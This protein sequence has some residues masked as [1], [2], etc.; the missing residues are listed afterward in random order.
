MYGDT[1]V[2]RFLGSASGL[3]TNAVEG[4]EAMPRV[5][6]AVLLSW[7]AGWSAIGWCA[8]KAAEYPVP[9]MEGKPCIH[10]IHQGRSVRVQRV[11]DPDF[12]LKGYYAKTT[13][14]FPPFC[15]HS[16]RA[17]LNVATVGEVELFEFMET[18]LRYGAGVLA[19]A[20]TPNWFKKWT[21]PGAVNYPFTE[22]SKLP[23]HPAW[24]K[25]LS[26]LG[27]QQI[28]ETSPGSSKRRLVISASGISK[29]VNGIS[30]T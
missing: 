27:A 26:E 12:E 5:L 6:S 15:I 29:R 14:R 25:V 11:Q 30:P 28:Q 1:R 19:D 8:E 13:C 24:G 17:A 18:K 4:D 10:T 16:M 3:R 23:Q 2:W 20:R 21:I 7:I 9:L 22:F